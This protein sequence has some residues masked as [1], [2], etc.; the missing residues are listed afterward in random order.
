VINAVKRRRASREP[1]GN[2]F[3]P[4][5]KHR[6]TCVFPEHRIRRP[7]Q[8]Q[9]P[10]RYFEPQFPGY[11]LPITT[12]Y[13][14]HQRPREIASS[15][16]R[17]TSENH[18]KQHWVSSSSLTRRRPQMPSKS[19]E[20]KDHLKLSDTRNVPWSNPKL[21]RRFDPFLLGNQ[22]R[23]RHSPIRNHDF[24]AQFNSS[25][26]PRE[27]RLGLMN[28]YRLHKDYVYKLSLSPN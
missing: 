7:R 27:I 1:A 10:H 6:R 9:L 24:F 21:A 3:N 19:Q 26:Q 12:A 4:R 18:H 5:P 13:S 2:L 11:W 28:I 20:A 8:R 16:K 17:S 14:L 23:N 25:Q 22:L 15:F